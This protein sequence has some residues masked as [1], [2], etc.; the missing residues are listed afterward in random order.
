MY[1][2]Y[3]VV[4]LRVAKIILVCV[5]VSRSA[6]MMLAVADLFLGGCAAAAATTQLNYYTLRVIN[7][8]KDG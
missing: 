8:Y 3:G 7:D 4:P 6:R 2:G 5:Y 1:I